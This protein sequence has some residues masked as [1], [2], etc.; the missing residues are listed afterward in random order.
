MLYNIF[1]GQIEEI[2]VKLCSWL[3]N[4]EEMKLFEIMATIFSLMEKRSHQFKSEFNCVD[5]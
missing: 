2:W 5:L 1:F 4:F 3:Q